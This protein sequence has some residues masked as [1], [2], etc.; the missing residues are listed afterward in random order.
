MPIKVDIIN[1]SFKLYKIEEERDDTNQI[2]TIGKK[3]IS[4][5]FM[6]NISEN[7][8]RYTL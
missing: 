4:Q 8:I 1:I 7:N 2:Y 6:I 5:R 3:V